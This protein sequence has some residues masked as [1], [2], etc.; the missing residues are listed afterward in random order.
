MRFLQEYIWIPV[1]S[2]SAEFNDPRSNFP[3]LWHTRTCSLYLYPENAR[4]ALSLSDIDSGG[5]PS[6]DFHEVAGGGRPT[7]WNLACAEAGI[8]D[9]GPSRPSDAAITQ[10]TRYFQI[11]LITVVSESAVLIFRVTWPGA[12]NRIRLDDHVTWLLLY[13]ISPNISRFTFRITQLIQL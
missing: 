1:S 8:A 3:W 13:Y 6:V 2:S 11:A 12:W 5:C 7:H 10:V 4:Y 9:P